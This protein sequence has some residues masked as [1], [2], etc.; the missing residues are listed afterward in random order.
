MWISKLSYLFNKQLLVLTERYTATLKRPSN[1]LHAAKF[2]TPISEVPGSNLRRDTDYPEVLRGSLQFLLENSGIMSYIKL[3]QLSLTSFP[4]HCSPSFSHLTL[5]RVPR[6]SI[7][8]LQRNDANGV[9]LRYIISR[10]NAV[11]LSTTSDA[12]RFLLDSAS[13][14]RPDLS[15]G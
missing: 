13:S 15:D 9:S 2:L 7:N 6:T 12:E 8:K 5:C 11:K 1:V 14:A 4:V 10:D 3:W